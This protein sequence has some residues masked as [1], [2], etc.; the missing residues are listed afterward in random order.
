LACE[1]AGS[2]NQALVR[3]F[4][5]HYDPTPQ[6][7]ANGVTA[8]VTVGGAVVAP[9]QAVAWNNVH[10]TTLVAGPVVTP[11]PT[12]VVVTWTADFGFATGPE[13]E[14]GGGYGYMNIPLTPLLPQLQIAPT[15]AYRCVGGGAVTLSV[16]VANM[17]WT[18]EIWWAVTP[19]GAGGPR[20]AVGG[21]VTY[22][23]GTNAV[24]QMGTNP[25][26]YTVT[27]APRGIAPLAAT[28]TVVVL[29][30]DLEASKNLLT[31]KHDRDC[32]LEVKTTPATGI[33]VDEYRID[34]KRTN[35][36]TW[37]VLS[38]NKTMT[39]WHGNIAGGFHLR[40]MA[41]IGGTE[42]YSTNI[43]VVNQFGPAPV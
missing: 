2:S 14:T 43:V 35:S 5:D 23:G 37:Y 6:V 3:L 34:I 11:N 9:G 15:A 13:E 21:G 8:G 12:G 19:T 1:N 30:V 31:L 42:C 33:T 25:G 26:V 32:N 4:M 17:A 10:D 16:A 28:A 7:Y 20:F 22:S 36:A 41:K 40:G 29:K 24:L 27:A 38:T 18:G 39:P